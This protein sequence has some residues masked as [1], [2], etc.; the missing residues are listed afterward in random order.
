MRLNLAPLGA[1]PFHK[2]RDPDLS[3][4]EACTLLAVFLL[5]APVQA[6]Q[7]PAARQVDT[8]EHAF[9]LSMPDP[10]RWMEGEN[11]AEFDGWLK[12]Q[13]AVSRRNLDALSNLA[14]WRQRLGA[15]AGAVTRHLGHRQSG[16][17]LFFLRAPAGKEAM[18][19]VREADGREHVIVDPAE[20]PGS[21]LSSY[22]ISPDGSRVA[23]N[24]GH[25]GSEIGELAV[26][27]VASGKRIPDTL[28]PVWS[29]F[30]S[31]WLPDGSGFFY[32]RMRDVTPDDSDPMQGSGAYLHRLG[33]PQARD[34]LIA[35]AGARDTLQISAHD[36][37]ST[38]VIPN[39][40][41]AVLGIGGAH[42]SLRICVARRAEVL[43]GKPPWRC[44]VGYD[45]NVQD[46]AL[47]GNS[48]YLLSA[49]GAANRR[50]LTIDLG[51]PD[52][53]VLAA[54]VAIPERADVVLTDVSAAHDGLYVRSMR[55]GLDH[56]ERMDYASSR[57]R[58]VSMP[59]DGTIALMETSPRLDGAL[60][61]LEGWIV[62]TRVYRYD[63][64]ADRLSD[65]GLGTVGAPSMPG[66]VAEETE[67]TSA[68]GT[69]VPMSVLRRGNLPVDGS[70]RAIV[71]GYGGY[72]ISMQPS[73]RP[74][75]LE[76]ATAGN[77]MAIC[78]VRGGG[79]N[80]DGW[81][82]AG[83]GPN[84]QRGV[85]DFIACAQELAKRG[86]TRPA[87]TAGFGASMGGVLTGGAYTTAPEAWGA[88]MVQS[89]IF[90]PVRLLAAKNGAN[91]IA[92]MGDPRTADG[93]K[94]LLAMDPYQRVRDG[95]RYPPLLLI[96]GGVDQRVAPWNSGK[97]G[98]RVMA[99]SPGTT[100]WFRTD[101]QFGHFATN[102]NAAALEMADVFAFAE[103][104]L[105]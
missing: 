100:V 71:F 68:D 95:V 28:R 65:L 36:F 52:G 43:A 31:S 47:R 1:V 54:R 70:V 14:A 81:R 91:Q 98:A 27:Y 79:E 7:A 20:D 18:L 63:P 89:G 85:E 21:S 101:G 35:R 80:G 59:G 75:L 82:V 56:V 67:A 11:N 34:R 66:L 33:D 46:M 57:L 74:L 58:P 49:K 104:E 42:A 102:A 50:V 13:G 40:D 41:W 26:F 45:D 105:K 73:F 2:Y 15:A 29:E 8:V 30:E 86:Y 55:H 76:W 3:V 48:L 78:H 64:A 25:G 87:R 94:Q 38:F 24:I 39:S 44:L 97:F 37:P 51:N 84:K 4:A 6:Q 53:G 22:S 99:A 69:K 10:Y 16:Q 72:G 103:A 83:T 92:E 32:T 60:L 9:G 61:S 88:M 5:A 17:R 77:V 96:T 90:N 12:T 19:M 23:V 62:P 93:T